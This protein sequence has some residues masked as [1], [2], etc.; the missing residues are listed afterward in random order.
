MSVKII[1]FDLDG[2]ILDDQK[3]IP[4]EKITEKEDHFQFRGR[5]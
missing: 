1:C 2:T 3:N 4:P 5:H